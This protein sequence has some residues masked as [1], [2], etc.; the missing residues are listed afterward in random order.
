MNRRIAALAIAASALLGLTACSMI[1]GLGTEGIVSPAPSDGA[2]GNGDAS[3]DDGQTAAEA[4][5]IIEDAIT[6]ATEGYESATDGD[7]T[8]VVEAM[9]AAAA[10][11]TELD[12]RSPTTRSR[13]CSRAY[14]SCTRT[15]PTSW[16]RSPAA[17]C[18]S[19]RR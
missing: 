2:V 18:P 3:G 11:L 1:P 7:L 10:D 9:R 13:R 14:R 15:P 19:S 8:T 5:A 17:T 16:R 4:C 12:P 6:S